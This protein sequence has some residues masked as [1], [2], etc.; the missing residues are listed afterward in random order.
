MMDHVKSSKS[1]LLTKHCCLLQSFRIPSLLM[2]MAAWSHNY[3]RCP[4]SSL[5]DLATVATSQVPV[6]SVPSLCPSLGLPSHCLAAGLMPG[7][8]NFSHV[9]FHHF[10]SHIINRVQRY[11]SLSVQTMQLKSFCVCVWQTID[12]WRVPGGVQET[13][14]LLL[15][16]NLTI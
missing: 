12:N 7:T 4:A 11:Y 1:C 13:W 6:P 10:T 15:P 14:P 3:L 5:C 8:V 9:I 16:R 2:R